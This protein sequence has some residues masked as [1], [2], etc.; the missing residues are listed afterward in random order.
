MRTS[1]STPSS[2]PKPAAREVDGALGARQDSDQGELAAKGDR[3][4]RDF[5]PDDYLPAP[6]EFTR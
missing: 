2:P 3:L 5:L 4:R 1:F 6:V